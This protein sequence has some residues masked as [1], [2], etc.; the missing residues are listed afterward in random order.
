EN[1]GVIVDLSEDGLGFQAAVR[2][3]KGR[4]VTFS[5][6]LGTGYRIAARARIAWVGP[7]GKTGGTTFTRMPEDSRSIIREWLA[8][9]AESVAPQE[10]AQESEP[11]A[12]LIIERVES[13]HVLVF[14]PPAP[15]ETPPEAAVAAQPETLA[16]T[17][18]DLQSDL[19]ADVHADVEA[20]VQAGAQVDAEPRIEPY[21]PAG[22]QEIVQSADQ[23][24]AQPDVDQNAQLVPEP[25]IPPVVEPEMQ[26][27]FA[28]VVQAAPHVEQSAAETVIEIPQHAR[29]DA[30][31][32]ADAP[33]HEISS[34]EIP[35]GTVS[36]SAPET[37][38][39]IAAATSQQTPPQT[40][41]GP[42]QRT[43]EREPMGTAVERE[44]PGPPPPSFP[45]RNT[46]ELF[47]RSPWISG[48]SLPEEERSH[49]ALIA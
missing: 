18:A 23:G 26:P 4:E 31:P 45:P 49:K 44:R 2:V 17:Q 24:I 29:E 40:A 6:T 1:G 7:T 41:A 32:P 28:P 25:A 47:S 35:P 13:R 39:E 20:D 36:E 19:H 3:E 12:P 5:F 43:N 22:L 14:P 21:V 38:A 27:T 11:A 30:A 34:P 8:K 33:L 9:V 16:E 48:Q 42:E 10:A 37:P 46:G 15:I